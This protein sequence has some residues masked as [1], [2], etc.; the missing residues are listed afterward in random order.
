M[1][2]VDAENLVY[3]Y[4]AML[5]KGFVAQPYNIVHQPDEY[6]WTSNIPV[7]GNH[8]VIRA[9]YYTSVTGDDDKIVS[10]AERIR[11]LDIKSQNPNS[12][13]KLHPVI[14]KKARKSAKAKS[15]DIQMT[16]DI[17]MHVYQNNLDTVCLF[18][19]DGDYR[20][21][22]TEAIR[23]GK[24]VYVAAFSDGFSP[25][26]RDVADEMIDLDPI[27]FDLNKTNQT[28]P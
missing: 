9:Y 26:L 11:Q 15:V 25:A 1:Y 10:V 28:S 20:P 24:N 12:A 19:G 5:Q 7:A 14:F 21:V 8:Q 18:S 23:S 13:R 6:L 22:L 27:F 2:F 4:Q 16:V 3:R 17:L